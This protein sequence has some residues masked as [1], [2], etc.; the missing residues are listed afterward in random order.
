MPPY[1]TATPPTACL[2]VACR[3]A[4]MEKLRVF[5]QRTRRAA[6]LKRRAQSTV[7]P[8][9]GELQHARRR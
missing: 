9:T 2:R 7:Q 1:S 5:F 8:Q 6:T 4:A 3:N